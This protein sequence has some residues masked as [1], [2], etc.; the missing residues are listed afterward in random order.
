MSQIAYSSIPVW[1]RPSVTDEPVAEGAAGEG[2]PSPPQPAGGPGSSRLLI[3]VGRDGAA[4][5][6]GWQDLLGQSSAP[7]H[8]VPAD[9]VQTAAAGL[10]S[11]LSQSRVGIRVLIAGSAGD[12]LALRAV[13]LGAGLA[14]DEIA[15]APCGAGPIE[16]ACAH[17]GAAT[18]TSA[19]V[20]S[21]ISC[22]GCAGRL[23]VYY[24]VSRRS[25]RFLGYL[26]D[27]ETLPA[28]QEPR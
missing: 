22:A 4:A 8:A 9:D 7:V 18:A 11:A 6:A 23:V 19:G 5:A 27:A 12:C 24:H 10:R 28:E 25:G 15:V 1:A 16:V 17:C 3:A 21:V 20:G 14:D 2:M 26:V 13:A